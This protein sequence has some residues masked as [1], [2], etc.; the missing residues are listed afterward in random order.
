MRHVGDEIAA[1]LIGLAQLGD[2]V[3]H[4]HRTAAG[5]GDRG[6]ARHQR[7]RGVAGH[8]QLQALGVFAEQRAAD[9]LDNARMADR[10][11][12]R[13]ID[14]S[15]LELE[16]AARRVVHQLQSTLLVHHQH[17]F[18]HAGEDCLHAG[19]IALEA[20]DAAAELVHRL[21]HRPRDVAEIIVLV[22]R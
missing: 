21:V 7:P 6:D 15:L 11:D 1:H 14:R 2:V 3:Q 4:Q 19:P 17:A 20:V 9:V 18:D 22:I 13:M 12:V 8:R 16:Q 10:L 5:G